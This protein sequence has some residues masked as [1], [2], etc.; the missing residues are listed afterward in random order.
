[1]ARSRRTYRRSTS[2][3]A[4]SLLASALPAPI[5]RIADTQWG[6]SLLLIGIPLLVV[7]GI[8]QLEWNGGLPHFTVDRNRAQEIRNAAREEFGRISGPETIQTIQQWERSALDLWNASQ[9]NSQST[10]V[11]QPYANN[12]NYPASYPQASN[13]YEYQGISQ[14]QPLPSSSAARYVS[15]QI[16]PQG[17][18]PINS[19]QNSSSYYYQQQASPPANY[20]QPLQ[21]TQQ[22]YQQPYY[23]P[24]LPPQQ[25]YGQWHQ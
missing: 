13:G 15:T 7:A 4:V 25:P 19:Y 20:Q 9:G 22:P 17:P 14:Q 6:S 10:N 5:Q 16:Q 11:S 18:A 12:A 24:P 2:Q 8:L 3:R 1:M 21:T 23:Q